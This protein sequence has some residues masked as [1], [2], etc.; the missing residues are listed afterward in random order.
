MKKS[1]LLRDL[2]LHI[3]MATALLDQDLTI[4]HASKDLKV[5]LHAPCP[6]G[7]S[8]CNHFADSQGMARQIR[9]ALQHHGSWQGW[10]HLR[11]PDPSGSQPLL[12]VQFDCH[13]LGSHTKIAV[14]LCQ[15]SKMIHLYQF[16][17]TDPLTG[18]PNRKSLILSL[19]NE[20]ALATSTKPLAL[21][22]LDVNHFK[23]INDLH[24]HEAGDAAL[25][26]IAARL[27][28]LS[29]IPVP[30]DIEGGVVGRLGGD[31]FC[32]A[33]RGNFTPEVLLVETCKRLQDLNFSMPFGKTV[34]HIRMSIGLALSPTHATDVSE[35]L[36]ASD[37]AM[38]RAKKTASMMP[39]CI[40]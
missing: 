15:M 20:I 40:E 22:Y 30:F 12:F 35:L 17:Y 4:T 29:K 7:S 23:Q 13:D 28:T 10:V 38:Y 2:S 1:Q 25:K 14:S 21:F 27:V 9:Q 37:R 6:I 36:R 18:L 11:S 5:L 26:E 19:Q 31:E 32:F 39:V 3:Q 8:L 16:A 24:G 33:V 34:L